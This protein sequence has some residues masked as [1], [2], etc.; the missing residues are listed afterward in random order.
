[1]QFCDQAL[2]LWISSCPAGLVQDHSEEEELTL[3]CSWIRNRRT[4]MLL[5]GFSTPCVLQ[6]SCRI[7]AQKL[8]PTL[9]KRAIDVTGNFYGRFEGCCPNCISSIIAQQA[10]LPHTSNLFSR[11]LSLPHHKADCTASLS[12]STLTRLIKV[13]E[14]ERTSM[15]G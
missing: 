15:Q 3:L 8:Q 5:E 6:G 11:E 9:P 7:Q 4:H 14:V 1:M 12:P 10:Q 13:W 2:D